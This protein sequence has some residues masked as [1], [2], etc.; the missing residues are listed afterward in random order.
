MWLVCINNLLATRRP[1][2]LA[3][4]FHMWRS[5]SLETFCAARET[6]PD[7]DKQLATALLFLVSQS[8]MPCMS[9]LRRGL[10]MRRQGFTRLLRRTSYT[11]IRARRCCAAKAGTAL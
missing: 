1:P 5:F 2:S 4:L 9:P 6:R 3:T 11:A 10:W 7:A 8:P